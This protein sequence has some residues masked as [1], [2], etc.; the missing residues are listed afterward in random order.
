MGRCNPSRFV[1]RL[2]FVAMVFA[3]PASA[4]SQ[5][6]SGLLPL[7]AIP[8]PGSPTFL[9]GCG[10]VYHLLLTS[11]SEGNYV[12]LRF[13]LC[14]AGPCAGLGPSGSNAFRCQLANGYA[15]CVS[16]GDSVGREPSTFVGLLDQGLQDRFD[17]DSDQRSNICFVEYTG[18][19]MRLLALPIVQGTPFS[20]SP[21]N[22]IR[23]A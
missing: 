3:G 16:V 15:C 13:P 20:S 6:C 18:N 1:F 10:T 8:P 22:I 19:G 23:F 11:G 5:V 4:Q 21:A 17:S 9:T 2:A 7:G 12:M 14:D